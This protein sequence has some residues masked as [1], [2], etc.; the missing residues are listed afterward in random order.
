MTGVGENVFVAASEQPAGGIGAD[1]SGMP[2]LH[3]FL[4]SFRHGHI[5]DV[6][7]LG[8]ERWSGYAQVV[9]WAKPN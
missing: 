5:S 1:C 8:G 7:H 3:Q 4:V 6:R 9:S 2:T